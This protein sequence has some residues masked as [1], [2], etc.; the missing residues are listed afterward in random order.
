MRRC[1]VLLFMALV[2]VASV[3]P[4]QAGAPGPVAPIQQIPRP[5]PEPADSKGYRVN[6]VSALRKVFREDNYPARPTGVAQIAAA[7]NEYASFQLVVEA[8][9]RAVR[10][11]QVRFADLEG[12]GGARIPASVVRW[13]RVEYVQTT[14]TPPY[15]TPRG[16]GWY[17]DPLMP[18]G[19]FTVRKLSRVPV[20]AG[21][22]CDPE[23]L[24]KR[25][26]GRRRTPAGAGDEQLR[27]HAA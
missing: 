2:C 15:P 24:R 17:P 16:L 11:T 23:V 7:R 21:S 13:D 25:A 26:V 27:A 9:W 12:P 5:L 4:A 6:V 8:P 19:P 3:L 10:V 22:G 14:V 18:A 20:W 1:L